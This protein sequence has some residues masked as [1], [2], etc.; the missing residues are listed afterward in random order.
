MFTESY[1][2]SEFLYSRNGQC[3]IVDLTFYE[4][5]YVEKYLLIDLLE[6]DSKKKRLDDDFK[7]HCDNRHCDISFKKIAACIVKG[8]H[9]KRNKYLQVISIGLSGLIWKMFITIMNLANEKNKKLNFFID[10]ILMNINCDL[11][12]PLNKIDYFDDI[13][14]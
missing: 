2:H 3:K 12:L 5:Q 10:S 1:R 4:K 9:L 7:V 14:M 8:H 11:K 6:I 13:I